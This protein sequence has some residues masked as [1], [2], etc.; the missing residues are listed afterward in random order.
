VGALWRSLADGNLNC[1]RH[2]VGSMKE[3]LDYGLA[4]G[5]MI[6]CSCS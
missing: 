3:H 6:K 2:K 1:G 4:R 5:L